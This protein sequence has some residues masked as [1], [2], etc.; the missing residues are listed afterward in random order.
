MK[1]ETESLLVATQDQNLSANSVL[2]ELD[3]DKCRLCGVEVKNVRHIM[4]AFEKT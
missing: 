4:S 3:S 2:E 1:G